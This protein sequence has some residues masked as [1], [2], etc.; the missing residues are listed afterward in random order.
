MLKPSVTR[1]SISGRKIV[2]LAMD[3]KQITAKAVQEIAQKF[4]IVF[5]H[6]TVL[7]QV[8]LLH[9][10]VAATGAMDA[11][12]VAPATAASVPTPVQFLQTFLPGFIKVMTSARKIDDII[13][14]KTVGSWEDQ[15]IV[16]GIV[17][18]A[19]TATE[20]GDFTN[21]PLALWNTNFI[22]RTIVRGELGIQVGLLEEGRSAAMRLSSAETKRQ[23]S[24]VGLEIFRNAVG[25]YGWNAGNNQTFGFLNDPNLPTYISSSVTDG[26]GS[27]NGTFQAITGDIRM[28]VVQLRTQSQD[29]IDPEKV[30][31]TLALPTDKV[32]YLTVTTDYGVSVRDWLE[33]TYKRIRVT[34]APELG[35][36][37]SGSDV[38]YL[39]AEE[40]DAS[41][42]GSTD[43]G[44]TFAQLVQTKFVTLGVEKRA[45][46]YIEDY[47]NG[48]AGSLCKRPWA[49]VRV[50]GI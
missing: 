4:G 32:D 37:D 47:S 22:K 10:Q 40:I 18:P 1:S 50:A 31:M 20:Y 14:V 7:E 16:Q 17:E 44:E 38:F 36:A 21:I 43:G 33:Q 35:A 12:F 49:V 11:A 34:S 2:P 48:T 3:S 6:A 19:A 24:A 39:F 23:G 42:D 5:D 8:Q 9:A 15:E 25:F 27:A 26:W 46:S 45:K 41:I 30:D 29:Q 13:G 28:A